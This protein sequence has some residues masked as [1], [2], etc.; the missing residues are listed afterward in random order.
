[1]CRLTYYLR[2]P[3]IGLLI[4]GFDPCMVY[5]QTVKEP[6]SNLLSNPIGRDVNRVR[7]F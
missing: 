4:R 6:N 7:W 2:P 3:V 1:M 5:V